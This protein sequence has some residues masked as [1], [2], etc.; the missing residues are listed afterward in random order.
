MQT[1][2]TV[3]IQTVKG[4]DTPS[5]TTMALSLHPQLPPS[6]LCLAVS[7]K[8]YNMY[9]IGRGV[10]KISCLFKMRCP[11]GPTNSRAAEMYW[12]TL[13]P[14]SY[15]QSLGRAMEYILINSGIKRSLWTNRGRCTQAKWTLTGWNNHRFSP[16]SSKTE[17]R[18]SWCSGG[19]LK[20]M[21]L[22]FS[23]SWTQLTSHACHTHRGHW[24][25]SHGTGLR[26]EPASTQQSVWQ[27]GFFFAAT[28]RLTK[29]TMKNDRHWIPLSILRMP[30][31]FRGCVC[32]LKVIY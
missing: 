24:L 20:A 25:H 29:I 2:R 17:G 21:S 7:V 22:G 3:G 4:Q 5:K 23:V 30:T 31:W 27:P 9:T 32:Y 26:K 8:P 15:T 11:S 18:A 19:E 28:S 1:A 10:G 13:Q 6:A 14:R 12:L 16:A